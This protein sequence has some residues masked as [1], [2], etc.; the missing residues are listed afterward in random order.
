MEASEPGR[1]RTFL[2]DR[3]DCAQGQ[4]EEVAFLAIVPKI[5]YIPEPFFFMQRHLDGLQPLLSPLQSANFLS[6]YFIK[7]LPLGQ[8]DRRTDVIQLQLPQGICGRP[9]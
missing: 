2:G 3:S 7:G 8:T 6:L 5:G 1:K 4:G 9:S